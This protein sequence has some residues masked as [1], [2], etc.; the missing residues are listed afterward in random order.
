MKNKID[1]IIFELY[2][3]GANKVSVIDAKDVVTNVAF[4][5]MCK[6]NACG[7]YGKCW[8]CPPDCGD[9]NQLIKSLEKYSKVLVFQTVGKLEDSYDFEGMTEYKKQ[10]SKIVLKVKK[11]LSANGIDALTLG[12]G[13]CGICERCSKRENELC[14][15]PDL[16]IYSL[17]SYGI[18]VYALSKSADMKYINGPNTVT[19]FSAVFFD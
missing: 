7:M 10:F 9:I 6:A 2:E 11:M 8:T 16:A 4:R 17:E 14:R 3:F 19:Y 15:F 18:D 13:D 12:A 1:Q 5:D